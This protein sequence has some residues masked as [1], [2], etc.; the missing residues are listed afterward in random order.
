MVSTSGTPAVVLT[1]EGGAIFSSAIPLLA[2]VIPAYFGTISE[3]HT[4]G[5]MD[6]SAGI[7][8]SHQMSTM[9]GANFT[10]DVGKIAAVFGLSTA[11][12]GQSLWWIIALVL[13]II[14]V[15]VT[16]SMI[17]GLFIGI[18]GMTAGVYFGMVNPSLIA[19]AAVMAIFAWGFKE[20]VVR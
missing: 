14:A 1:P 11:M 2:S 19:V 9:M 20:F 16:R 4:P 15:A 10:A 13:A 3:A 5:E 6:Y 17:F 18:A 8:T 7:S 12:A